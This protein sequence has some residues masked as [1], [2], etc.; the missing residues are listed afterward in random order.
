M[1]QPIATQDAK[2]N[3]RTLLAKLVQGSASATEAT[4]VT[5]CDAAEKQARQ[6][7]AGLTVVLEASP[8]EAAIHR[9]E[10]TITLTYH[11][12]AI[13]QADAALTAAIASS[14]SPVAADSQ[15]L[16][17][18]T[19]G[20]RVAK[21]NI[22]VLI[23]GS[24]GT[25]KEV[26]ARFLHAASSRCD[27][28]FVAV[29]CAA[30]P[31]SMLEAMLFGHRK[32]AFTGASETHEGFFRAADKGT[33]LLDEI[34][35]MPITLQAKLLRALQEGEVTPI[36]ATRAIKVD[37]RVLAC[38]N[39]HLPQEIEEG[40]F[41]EDLYYRLNVFPLRI[42]SLRDR[43]DDIAPLA[44]ALM[45]KHASD[46]DQPKWITPDAISALQSHNWPG[47]VR[48]LE[49][50]IRRAMLLAC[51]SPEIDRS[52]IRFDAA[53]R[54][55]GNGAAVAVKVRPAAETTL[56]DISFRSEADAIMQMLEK[57]SG[58]RGKTAKRLGISER[59]LRYR[60]ASI[61]EAGLATAGAL[62]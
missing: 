42:P 18:L 16:A 26:M 15:T 21:S 3:H 46:H 54:I 60:L 53:A 11:Q 57:C 2:K 59:T 23:E 34:G 1:T 40:R 32:G 6:K 62:S 17:L 35:E 49:N 29:N 61:R 44:F 43:P 14:T 4:P 8:S 9:V 7:L 13:E 10:N 50:V 52:H 39:R 55:V 20:E 47:N 19:L 56:S 38:T 30:M 33:L 41:R 31:E 12:N 27:E 45:L 25:G 58:H 51:N 37:V 48:E 28:P 24:T 5:I 22:P 36:G